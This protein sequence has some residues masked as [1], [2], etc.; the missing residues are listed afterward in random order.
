MD[1]KKIK[2]LLLFPYLRTI[3]GVK[4]GKFQFKDLDDIKNETQDNR[5]ELGRIL[6]TFRQKETRPIDAFNYLALE[7]TQD[8]LNKTFLALKRS[9]EIFRYLTVDPRGKGMEVEHTT[10]YAVFPDPK[11]P[12]KLQEKEEHFMYRIHENFAGKEQ[13][14]SFPHASQR[15]LFYKDIY[16]DS[17]PSIDDK[18]MAKLEGNLDNTDLRAI[19]W[20]NK[21]FSVSAVDDKENLLR[22]SGAFESHFSLDEEGGRQEALKK[23]SEIISTHIPEP[24]L[25]KIL[26]DIKPFTTPMII[27]RLAETVKTRTS[28][29]SITKWF[30]K[31]F[32]SV[33]SGIRHGDEVAEL[34]KPVVSKNKLGKSVWYAG[35]ASH[36]FLNNVYFGQRLFKFLLE[37]KYFPYNEHIRKMALEQLEELL[38]SDEERLKIL[39]S[40]L[41]SRKIG[42]ITPDDIRIAF[43]FSGTFYGNKERVL[44]ILK[45]L[46][47]ELKTKQD[48][49][50]EILVH[51]D[52]LLA[53]KL[54]EQD[55]SDY[56]KT[57]PFYHALIEIDSIF[58][59]KRTSLQVTDEEMKFF[60]IR[61]FISFAV[62]RL[63]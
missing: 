51:G 48:I 63:I 30:R 19:T 22:L 23:I 43:S 42:E 36:E 1:N 29:D 25:K 11:N 31:H 57:K 9:L 50:S 59:D 40:A 12:W 54:S 38:V 44:K 35:D 8:G 3:A 52:L 28:S 21:T 10:L 16:G 37:D 26:K 41:A 58:H 20:Y 55:F 39:E 15:P 45:R 7:D 6:S 62:H 14:A 53:A 27:K 32:Y 2:V 33:G 5:E 34:P 17:P 61:Q 4:V 13:F 49:W 18:L 47:E 56:E 46:L 24:E 60:Y